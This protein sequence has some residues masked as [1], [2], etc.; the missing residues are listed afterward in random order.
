MQEPFAAQPRATGEPESPTRTSNAGIVVEP[1]QCAAPLEHRE[2]FLTDLRCEIVD[3]PPLWMMRQAGR[4]LPEYRQL[5][6]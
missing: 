5:K 4:C 6:E 3:R 2:R 1:G